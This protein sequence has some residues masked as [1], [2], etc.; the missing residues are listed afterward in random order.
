MTDPT[1]IAIG[2][3][4]A[5]NLGALGYLFGVQRTEI[6]NNG[7]EIR[8]LREHREGD[9]KELFGALAENDRDCEGRHSRM[10]GSI[11]QNAV[12]IARV[13]SGEKPE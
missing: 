7:R 2:V 12:N 5:I 4:I 1:F 11:Q 9:R 6:K 3:N 10:R 13:H 8:R